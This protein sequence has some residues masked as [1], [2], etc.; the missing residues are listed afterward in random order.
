MVS[1]SKGSAAVV[2][3][4]HGNRNQV[5]GPETRNRQHPSNQPVGAKEVRNLY[6]DLVDLNAYL[7]NVY[8]VKGEYTYA[9]TPEDAISSWEEEYDTVLPL[10]EAQRVKNVFAAHLPTGAWIF[11][12]M[13]EEANFNGPYETIRE[14]IVERDHYLEF[15]DFI[16]C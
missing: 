9:D 5:L 6:R 15:V 7:F 13:D 2:G 1:S 12:Y 14:A 8:M 16:G 3:S 4:D 11:V 10:W